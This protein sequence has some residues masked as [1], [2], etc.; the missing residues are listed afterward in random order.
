[1]RRRGRRNLG[2]E[3]ASIS[4]WW[5]SGGVDASPHVQLAR[6]F[7]LSLSIP[8]HDYCPDQLHVGSRSASGVDAAS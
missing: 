2:V 1:M 4:T 3:P 6:G 7:S 5:E 8:I